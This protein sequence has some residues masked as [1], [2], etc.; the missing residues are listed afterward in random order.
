[1]QSSA[2][3]I[4]VVLD[5]DTYN[6]VDD[7]FALAH[8][9][10]APEAVEVE[11]VHAAPFLNHRSSSPEDGMEKSYE[12]IG[13]VLDLVRRHPRGGVFKGSRRFMAKAD[14]PVESPAALDLI[15]R[16][17]NGDRPLTV[18]AIGAITNVA[19]ALLIE[20]RIAERIRIVWLGGHAP[21]WPDTREFNLMQDPHASRIVMSGLAPLVQIPCMGVASHMLTSVYELDALLAPFSKLGAYL[22]KIV[23]GYTDNPEGWSKQI[24]DLAASAYIIDPTPFRVERRPSPIITEELTWREDASRPEIEIVTSLKRDAI[25]RDFFRRARDSDRS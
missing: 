7:Q 17:M 18:C 19:S 14:E 2:Q 23:R 24:W 22:S 8:L 12:E 25:F 21:S 4:R 5:T 13:R 20:P 1:M 6:E 9:M 3:P 15:E 16:A 10:L 11:A